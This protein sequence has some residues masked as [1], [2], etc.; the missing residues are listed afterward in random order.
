MGDKV[1]VRSHFRRKPKSDIQFTPSSEFLR[2]A[3]APRMRI[4]DTRTGR[5][6]NE[7]LL[8]KAEYE[9]KAEAK[10]ARE[11]GDLQTAEEMEK[12]VKRIQSDERHLRELAKKS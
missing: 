5:V 3:S 8:K 12:Q 6:Y 9:S 4:Q 10:R 7:T 2:A 1:P 11:E